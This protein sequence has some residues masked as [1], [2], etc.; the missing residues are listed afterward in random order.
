MTAARALNDRLQSS[1]AGSVTLRAAANRS[2]G[3]QDRRAGRT[4]VLLLVDLGS[5]GSVGPGARF[6]RKG[7]LSPAWISGRREDVT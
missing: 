5:L 6:R 4:R 2:W 7:T 1:R 3:K